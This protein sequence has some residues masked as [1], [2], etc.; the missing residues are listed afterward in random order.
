MIKETDFI[1][2]KVA[3]LFKISTIC[4]FKYFTFGKPNLTL[5]SLLS[6]C[7][8]LANSTPPLMPDAI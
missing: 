2:S 1:F 5:S 6:D 7:M 4:K 8:D 3:I